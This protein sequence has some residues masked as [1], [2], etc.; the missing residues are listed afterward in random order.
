VRKEVKVCAAS[1]KDSWDRQVSLARLCP[2]GANSGC[3]SHGRSNKSPL[4]VVVDGC[5]WAEVQYL[6]L[7]TLP[8]VKHPNAGHSHALTGHNSPVQTSQMYNSKTGV[9]HSSLRLSATHIGR[10]QAALT[11]CRDSDHLRDSPLAL[12]I[13]EYSRNP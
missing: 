4:S 13:S 2:K 5:G 12:P 7:K 3:S 1:E 6:L 10:R 8:E 9:F 11:R